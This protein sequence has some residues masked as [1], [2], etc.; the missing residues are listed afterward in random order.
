MSGYG[1][2]RQT[3]VERPIGRRAAFAKPRK[4]RNSPIRFLSALDIISLYV[5]RL[6]QIESAS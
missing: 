3:T 4:A 1:G 5:L 2:C 6:S